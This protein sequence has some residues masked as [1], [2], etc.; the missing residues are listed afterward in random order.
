MSHLFKKKKKV[1]HF[2]F[3]KFHKSCYYEEQLSPLG[4]KL[5]LCNR[6]MY[7]K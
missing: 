1:S 5:V 4:Q 2:Y 7:D 6:G 3:Q